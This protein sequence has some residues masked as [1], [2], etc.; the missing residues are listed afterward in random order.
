[1]FFLSTSFLSAEVFVNFSPKQARALDAIAKWLA[2]PHSKQTFYLAGYAGVG[3]TSVLRHVIQDVQGLVL[4]GAFTGR[5]AS[6][7][8]KAGLP[9]AT[10]IHRILYKPA[11]DP[12]SLDMIERTKKEVERLRTVN[13]AGA[14]ATA[15]RLTAQLRTMEEEAKR[16]G[17][18]FA[19]NDGTDLARAKLCV[20]D[21]C[22]FVSERIGKDLE[23]FGCKLLVVGD[24]AQ[25]PPV[26]GSGYFTAREPDFFLDEV[27]RQA[28]DS[29]I[30]RLADFARRGERLP[31]GK[32]GDCE[33]LHSGDPS[34]QDRALAADIVIVGRNRTRHASNA[35]I[36]RLL[37]RAESPAPVLGDKVMGLRNDHELGILNGSQWTVSRSVPNYEAMTTQL[38]LVSADE[39]ADRVGCSSWLHHFM[40]REDELNRLP[41]RDHYEA[42]YAFAITC[43]KAQGGGFNNVLVFDE[44]AAFGKDAHRWRYTAITRSIS[45]VEVVQ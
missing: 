7:M 36:R 20:I 45:R 15:D 13:D 29:P 33:V 35:K 17:P 4:C 21:E 19:L 37:G 40:A 26:F 14:Q 42:D 1:L 16:S 10:T 34:L 27:H 41:R 18:R 39:D 3:K 2:D 44:S 43:H 12:P 28:L 23:S 6:V 25:L 11:G 8:R 32:H 24:P 30:L 38:D 9:N 31:Y 5:A 22:S